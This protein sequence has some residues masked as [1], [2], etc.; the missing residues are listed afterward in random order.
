MELTKKRV[1]VEMKPAP[2][3]GIKEHRKKTLKH[4]KHYVK[5][6]TTLKN[7]KPEEEDSM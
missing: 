6:M 2:I 4:I 1:A 5:V 7:K 3:H